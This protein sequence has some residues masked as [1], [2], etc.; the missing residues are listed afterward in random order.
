MHGMIGELRINNDIYRVLQEVD[1]E[2]QLRIVLKLTAEHVCPDNMRKG[3]FGITR[4]FGGDEDHPTFLNFSHI[5][6]L[7]SLSTPLEASIAGNVQEKPTLMLAAVQVTMKQGK[8]QQLAT[9]E[10]LRERISAK[11]PELC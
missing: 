7:L 4:S 8:K 11:L 10:K 2:E 9:Y 1:G 5:Y 6:R 3:F